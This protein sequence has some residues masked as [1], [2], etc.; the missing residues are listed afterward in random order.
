MDPVAEVLERVLPH[1][2]EG[3]IDLASEEHSH[4]LRTIEAA[5]ESATQ[6]RRELLVERLYETPFLATR[7]AATDEA[8]LR[9]PRDSYLR[10]TELELWFD[11][12]PQAF[13]VAE[14]QMTTARL[15]TA[16]VRTRMHTTARKPQSD[17][18]VKIRSEHGDHVR[19]VD[20]FDPDFAVDGLDWALAHPNA[21]RSEMIWNHVLCAYSD[22]LQ[23]V[24]EV[25][26]R[27]TFDNPD[28]SIHRSR[29]AQAA[30]TLCWIPGPAGAWR[31]PADTS[32]EDLPKGWTHN[33]IVAEA[34]GMQT[35]RVLDFAR[36]IGFET[37]DIQLLMA[38]PE[39]RAKVKA[40]LRSNRDQP[41]FEIDD[42][43][44][45]THDDDAAFRVEPKDATFY[46]QAVFG[47]GDGAREHGEPLG[48]R[49][50]APDP[51]RRRHQA[52]EELRRYISDARRGGRPFKRVPTNVWR[53]KDSAVRLGLYQEYRGRCQICDDT[54]PKRNGEPYFEGI[55]LIPFSMA[56]WAD[57]MGNALCLCAG[58]AAR[59]QHGSVECED[60]LAQV[61][62]WKARG[63][64]GDACP[65]I[66]I[67]LCGKDV[68][69]QFTERHM[70]ELQEL[71][72]AGDT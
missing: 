36:E 13:F 44:E 33:R 70:I 64:G 37:E 29:A 68:T 26:T 2:R 11:G 20:G 18:H 10:S 56:S 40:F 63:E 61:A 66:K 54:F 53:K 27:Q 49:G 35:P 60:V 22:C 67:A 6:S 1:Y 23:G 52:Q 38:S 28:G 55:A 39:M 47:R 59:F 5:L 4:N 72:R 15:K 24:V 31:S 12:N 69:I 14:D 17:G 34:L 62:A 9:A 7:N 50:P 19:G 21:A 71:M 58:C 25:S 57:R 46:V 41:H 42:D 45:V 30:S 8:T 16:G 51:I 43:P 48:P 3:I 65:I 32:L